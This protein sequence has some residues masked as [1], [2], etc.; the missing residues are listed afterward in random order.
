MFP[1]PVDLSALHRATEELLVP[2]P[3]KVDLCLLLDT[4]MPVLEQSVPPIALLEMLTFYQLGRSLSVLLIVKQLLVILNW[5]LDV[6]SPLWAHPWLWEPERVTLLA[7]FWLSLLGKDSLVVTWVLPL[8]PEP[9]NA[10]VQ[11][12]LKVALDKALLRAALFVWPAVNQ[13]VV[14][15]PLVVLSSRVV[16]LFMRMLPLDPSIS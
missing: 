2:W 7:V 5:Q 4:V 8:V 11:W 3:S 12:T 13:L 1:A 6:L 16:M 14:S 9:S 15:A 10:E